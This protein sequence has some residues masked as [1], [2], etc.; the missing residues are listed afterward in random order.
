MKKAVRLFVKIF[1]VGYLLFSAPGTALALTQSPCEKIE[2]MDVEITVRTDASVQVTER[3]AVQACGDKIQRGI[4][5]VLPEEGL[6]DYKILSV[7]RNGLPERYFVRQSASEQTIYIGDKNTRLPRGRYVY[8]IAYQAFDAVRFQKDFDELYWN[9]TG[10]DWQFPIEQASVRISLPA[11]AAIVPQGISLY[12]GYKNETGSPSAKPAGE[13]LFCTTRPLAPGEGF[14]I[15]AAWNKGVVAPLVRKKSLAAAIFSLP[16]RTISARAFLA[17]PVFQKGLVIW[18]V[19][20]VYY[21]VLWFWLRRG[22]KARVVRQSEPPQGLSPA[23][24]RYVYHMGYDD[25]MLSIVVM[26]LV[27]KGWVRVVER[28]ARSY[29]IERAKNSNSLPLS[30]EEQQFF[31]KLLEDR[32]SIEVTRSHYRIFQQARKTLKNVLEKWE[33]K[34]LFHRHTWALLPQWLFTCGVVG[35]LLWYS[36]GV[37]VANQK[38]V[39]AAIILAWFYPF[40]KS[41][42]GISF[43]FFTWRRYVVCL[44]SAFAWV[45]YGWQ[46]AAVVLV[47]LVPGVVFAEHIGVYTPMGRKMMDEIEGFLQYMEVAEQNRVFSSNPTDAA[48]I[49]CAY[50]PYAAALNI[51]NKWRTSF[52]TQIGSAVC[53]SAE[54][55]G[56]FSYCR[57]NLFARE[58]MRASLA[59]PSS[60]RSSSSGFGGGGRVGGGSSGGGGGG[61]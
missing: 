31:D 26:S 7:R 42:F 57:R 28:G 43:K 2:R 56:G 50:L 14:T 16:E 34:R 3:I 54:K 12:T 15:S 44:L 10:N 29:S 38:T 19:L 39:M 59:S 20:L 17:F 35:V 4:F 5:R 18:G 47:A 60:G 11:G 21:G 61:W 53:Q 36:L 27:Q 9:V 45:A 8:E 32:E 58:L 41:I 46:L 52:Q 48:R 1:C 49:Y 40:L 23:Q 30:D 37:F 55:A 51:Q 24:T 33:N 13:Q 22:S 25:E 6:S